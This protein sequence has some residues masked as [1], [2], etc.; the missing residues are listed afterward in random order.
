MFP[1]SSVNCCKGSSPPYSKKFAQLVRTQFEFFVHVPHF[2]Y[3]ILT[4]F[5]G[6]ILFAMCHSAFGGSVMH[7]VNVRA[8][9]QM[10]RPNTRANIALV[11]NKHPIRDGAVC[12]NPRES[13][14]KLPSSIH[15]EPTMTSLFV[16]GSGPKPATLS[17]FNFTPESR[18]KRLFFIPVAASGVAVNSVFSSLEYLATMATLTLNHMKLQLSMVREG[19]SVLAGTFNSHIVAS[20]GLFGKAKYDYV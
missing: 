8:E 10:V 5:V 1:S 11:A 4:Q 9:K 3:L 7:I 20:L 13:M 15:H 16:S 19:V 17:F 2:F 14:C 6:S 18:F 12:E